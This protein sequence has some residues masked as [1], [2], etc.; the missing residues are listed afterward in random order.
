MSCQFLFFI[1]RATQPPLHN[2]NEE[3]NEDSNRL[4]P[5]QVK[6]LS[7]IQLPTKSLDDQNFTSTPVTTVVPLTT[8][9]N[10]IIVSTQTLISYTTSIN[11]I[12]TMSAMNSTNLTP[13]IPCHDLHRIELNIEKCFDN[14]HIK[15]SQQINEIVKRLDN[16]EGQIVELRNTFPNPINTSIT[17]PK[18]DHIQS[19]TAISTTTNNNNSNN[20]VN[21]NDS[22]AN[23]HFP[24]I[25]IK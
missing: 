6:N 3:A 22:T 9:P 15:L 18:I 5:T 12:T 20:N 2:L 7:K 11:T 4:P 10:P 19:N 23:N 8:D 14:F 24:K 21:N 17:E 1:N 13:N 16:L 25:C